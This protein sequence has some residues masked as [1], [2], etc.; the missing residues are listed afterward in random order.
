MKEITLEVT[1]RDKKGKGVARKLRAA[2]KIPAVVYGRGH[3]PVKLDIDYDHFHLTYHALR[4][5]NALINLTINGQP[6]ENKALIRDIQH[7]PVHGDI[8][9]IDFQYILM[10]EKIRMSVPVKLI[11]TAAG[12]KNFSGVLQWTY[13]DL[14]ILAYPHDV[15]DHI[16]VNVEELNIGDA[17]HIKDLNYPNLDFVVDDE[18]TII[19]VIAPKVTKLP[20]AGEEEGEE[21]GAAEAPAEEEEKEPEVISEKKAEGRQTDKGKSE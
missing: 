10:N 5:E 12:V 15:P 21:E 3:D 6:S 16:E 20:A 19:S 13:R 7:D 17:V 14:D 9:H 8:M 4:G 18:E 1:K 2:D 11:G